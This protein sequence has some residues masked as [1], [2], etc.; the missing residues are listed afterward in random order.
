MKKYV[1]SAAHAKKLKELG[2]KQESI[3][4]WAK[5]SQSTSTKFGIGKLEL[6]FVNHKW[7][8]DSLV[9]HYS[10]FTIGE[11]GEMLPYNIIEFVQDNLDEVNSDL[12]FEY[13]NTVKPL[14]N[15]NFLA[16]LLICLIEN[17]LMKI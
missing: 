4:F 3:W 6:T 17:K 7:E 15:P 2:V 8:N 12:Y 16:D 9:E 13:C 11:L 14:F 10:A 5:C 1:C